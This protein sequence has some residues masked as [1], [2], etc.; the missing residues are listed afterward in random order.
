MINMKIPFW[1]IKK[2]FSAEVYFSENGF[3]MLSQN[4]ISNFKNI[5]L[6]KLW[7]RKYLFFGE[8]KAISFETNEY[9]FFFESHPGQLYHCDLPNSKISKKTNQQIFC[10]FWYPDLKSCGLKIYS[11][12]KIIRYIESEFDYAISH[13]EGTFLEDEDNIIKISK[14]FNEQQLKQYLE[15]AKIDIPETI[16][17]TTLIN[18]NAY[19][20]IR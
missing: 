2:P 13:D 15:N 17:P 11:E 7:R 10:F 8:F 18:A 12:N 6:K 9:F 19:S 16:N 20:L 5:D 1:V 4:K 3:K 14:T